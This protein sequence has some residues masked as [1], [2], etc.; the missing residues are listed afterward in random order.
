M[1]SYGRLELGRTVC[2]RYIEYVARSE[3]VLGLLGQV[4]LKSLT[5]RKRWLTK[6]C[7]CASTAVFLVAFI[8]VVD[9]H[10]I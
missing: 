10:A 9:A 6:S 3:P 4:D 8:S 1:H 7:G 5:G 2:H